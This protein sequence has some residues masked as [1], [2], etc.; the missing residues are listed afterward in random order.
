MIHTPE[1]IFA[2]GNAT[3]FLCSPLNTMNLWDICVP[4]IILEEAGGRITYVHGNTIDY[5]HDIVNHFGV[6]ASNKIIHE[7]VLKRIIVVSK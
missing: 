3:L 4:H 6:V 7:D 1:E 2:K 5:S